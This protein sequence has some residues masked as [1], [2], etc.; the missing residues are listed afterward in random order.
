MNVAWSSVRLAAGWEASVPHPGWIGTQLAL[1]PAGNFV[2]YLSYQE[3]GEDS[4][5]NINVKSLEPSFETVFTT[6]SRVP[7]KASNRPAFSPN[8]RLLV[9]PLDQSCRLWDTQTWV[10]IDVPYPYMD[11]GN[12]E[13][14]RY[15]RDPLWSHDSTMCIVSRD[16]AGWTYFL[17]APAQEFHRVW[18]PSTR[19]RC[20]GITH[21]RL[22]T[23]TTYWENTQP[24]S[25]QECIIRIETWHWRSKRFTR[26][27]TQ[28]FEIQQSDTPRL[29]FV[30][31]RN[32]VLGYG[33][34]ALRLWNVTTGELLWTAALTAGWEALGTNMNLEV[35]PNGRAI[36]ILHPLTQ[37][38][39]FFSTTSG[40]NVGTVII[41]A[42]GR[43]TEQRLHLIDGKVV[44]ERYPG[45]RSVTVVV[46]KWLFVE[47]H[48]WE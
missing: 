17:D 20:L 32:A 4:N 18:F 36:A 2:A 23:A 22:Y 26:D 19:F 39:A 21:H 5:Y 3:L 10:E 34:E 15:F 33:A 42:I 37:E 31:A 11:E 27:S 6:R 9:L 30:P 7:R 29:H 40:A 25:I 47:E 35:T 46:D 13:A 8:G 14:H 48:D 38:I 41:D 43:E 24:R 45:L 1:S 28:K 12:N 44:L 16:V